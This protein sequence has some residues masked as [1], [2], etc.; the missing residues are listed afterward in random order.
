MKNKSKSQK[1]LQEIAQLE[2]RPPVDQS[3][4]QL[5]HPLKE[6]FIEHFYALDGNVSATCKASQINRDTYYYWLKTDQHFNALIQEQKNQLLDEI[7]QIVKNN[8]RQP[9]S[10][11]ERIFW[12]K[13]HHPDYKENKESIAFKNNDVQF[14]LTRG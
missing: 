3:V 9:Q 12:L 1:I 5:R 4:R 2:T 8:A 7:D 6:R 10:I 14:V 11:T 13:T